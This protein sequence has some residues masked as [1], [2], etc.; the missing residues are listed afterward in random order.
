[1]GVSLTIVRSKVKTI[2]FCCAPLHAQR[3]ALLEYLRAA[4]DHAIGVTRFHRDRGEHL[5]RVKAGA[6]RDGLDSRRR[7]LDG[8]GRAAVSRRAPL[9]SR[10]RRTVS[11]WT[12]AQP[13]AFAA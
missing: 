5:T 10:L 7:V 1:M 12:P 6:G 13:S 8:I 4:D 2:R 3:S 11:G 9:A